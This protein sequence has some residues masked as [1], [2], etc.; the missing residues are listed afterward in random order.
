MEVNSLY[1]NIKQEEALKAVHW[2]LNRKSNIKGKQKEF[3]S[4]ALEL[5][6]CSN[7]FRHN[8]KL[9]RQKKGIAMGAKF[10]PSIVNVFMSKWEE[11][12]MYV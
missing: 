1:T 8:K 3:L 11:E 5:A 10:T 7:Y 6:I 4:K 2:A 9:F 12:E